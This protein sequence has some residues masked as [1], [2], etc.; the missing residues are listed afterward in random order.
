M[1]GVREGAGLAGGGLPSL[2]DAPA[3]IGQPA[4]HGVGRAGDLR[5][6]GVLVLLGRARDEVRLGHA[7]GQAG[8]GDAARAGL[9]GAL[10]L[11]GQL[12]VGRAAPGCGGRPL[13]GLGARP[14]RSRRLLRR[15]LGGAL[16]GLRLLRT[17]GLARRLLL[18]GGPAGLRLLVLLLALRALARLLAAEPV[19]LQRV[20]QRGPAVGVAVDRGQVALRG[21]L[22]GAVAAV[23]LP[24]V[25]RRLR[26]LTGGRGVLVLARCREL[27][28]GRGVLVLALRR[29]LT[30]GRRVLVLARRRELTG[31]RGVLRRGRV[32]L[33]R[34]LAAGGSAG[35]CLLYT[36]R[37]V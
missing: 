12:V 27:A 7:L 4:P 32:A 34:V 21:L 11:A 19:G 35:G 20:E 25:G 8:R 33:L 5:P 6:A 37:C 2:R 31:G 16:R 28:G 24:A 29:E 3:E 26:E 10:G 18:R 23:L 36:S 1:S 14:L 13:G 17:A 15:L 9:A 22:L 30:G